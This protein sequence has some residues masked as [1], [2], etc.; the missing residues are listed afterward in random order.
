M[1]CY[2]IVLWHIILQAMCL[3]DGVAETYKRIA[4]S[5]MDADFSQVGY[6]YF[7]IN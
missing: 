7:R 5:E 1:P 3:A 6:L 2:H 4:G